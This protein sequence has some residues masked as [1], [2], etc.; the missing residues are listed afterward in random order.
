[1]DRE[2]E[3]HRFAELLQSFDDLARE[4]QDIQV[5]GSVGLPPLGFA[6]RLQPSPTS[7]GVELSLWLDGGRLSRWPADG[8]AHRAPFADRH[9]RL[10]LR[11]TFQWESLAFPL[12]EQLARTMLQ[13]MEDQIGVGIPTPV[14]VSPAIRVE[15][16]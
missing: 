2:L 15:A 1:M 10:D 14:P 8:A 13:W 3:L 6:I 5:R 7:A 12:A 9:V 4:R 11:S 16:L